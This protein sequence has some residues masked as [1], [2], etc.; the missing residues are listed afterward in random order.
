MPSLRDSRRPR[1]VARSISVKFLS[2]IQCS[3]WQGNEST[4]GMELR[5]SDT[6]L[7]I[8]LT[9]AFVHGPTVSPRHPLVNVHEREPG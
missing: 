2:F 4:G 3:R 6:E 7:D 9:H 8:K 1:L 5:L